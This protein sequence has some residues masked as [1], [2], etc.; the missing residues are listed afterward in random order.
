MNDDDLHEL[1]RI[2]DADPAAPKLAEDPYERR[3][4]LAAIV[5]AFTMVWTVGDGC[6]CDG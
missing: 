1:G 4:Q 5:R 2:L 3:E 6:D